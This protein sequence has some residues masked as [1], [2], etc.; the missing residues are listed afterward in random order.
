MCLEKQEE[1]SQYNHYLTPCLTSSRSSSSS[2]TR[3]L[4]WGGEAPGSK[5]CRQSSPSS[6]KKLFL[7]TESVLV[8]VYYWYPFVI[9][10]V[11]CTWQLTIHWKRVE[12]N[13][14]QINSLFGSFVQM[15]SEVRAGWRG[16]LIYLFMRETRLPFSWQMFCKADGHLFRHQSRSHYLSQYL[17]A[18]QP[19]RFRVQPTWLQEVFAATSTTPG[20]LNVIKLSP[21]SP[22]LYVYLVTHPPVF[23]PTSTSPL[24]WWC[25]LPHL[26]TTLGRMMSHDKN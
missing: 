9:I 7:G 16:L 12:E 5:L 21:S 22:A 17:Y 24:G 20:I 23:V 18:S 1:Q 19:L 26:S 13:A 8:V 10:H 15:Y 3:S 11:F 14:V 6:R 4:N 2:R 25:K